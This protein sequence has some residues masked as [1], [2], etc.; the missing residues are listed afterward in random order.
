MLGP[1]FKVF[2]VGSGTG[3][4]NANFYEMI[5]TGKADPFVVGI[6]HVQDLA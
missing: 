4:L 5:K 2:D 6:E 3:T 1:G